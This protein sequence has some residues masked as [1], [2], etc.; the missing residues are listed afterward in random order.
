MSDIDTIVNDIVL[1]MILMIDIGSSSQFVPTQ[2]S[3]LYALVYIS[4]NSILT[5]KLFCSY[6]FPGN[7][8]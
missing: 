1:D 8:S 3:H 5:I 2:P 6:H 4:Y 7:S